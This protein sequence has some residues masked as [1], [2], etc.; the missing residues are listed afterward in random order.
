LCLEGKANRLA[1]LQEA[2]RVQKLI[3]VMVMLK[4]YNKLKY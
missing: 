1:A 2:L 3:K 4:V